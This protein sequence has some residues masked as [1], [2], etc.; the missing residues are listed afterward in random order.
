MS[1]S[2]S[3]PPK[4]ESSAKAD[5]AP[6]RS[7][8]GYLLAGGAVLIAAVFLVVRQGPDQRGTHGAVPT[9]S[10]A[11]PERQGGQ[12]TITALGPL[13]VGDTVGDGWRVEKIEAT[14]YEVR[15]GVSKG[16]VAATL[17]LA[18]PEGRTDTPMVAIPDL[19]VWYSGLPSDP[20]TGALIQA[21]AAKLREG[22]GGAPL[23]ERVIAWGKEAAGD[24]R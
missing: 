18:S 9:G 13:R 2:E 12:H 11:A 6:P 21:V 20:A 4:A 1:S 14:T 22:A 17:G 5:S 19:F 8:R 3:T 7:M 23:H 24:A 16:G 15:L 10:A